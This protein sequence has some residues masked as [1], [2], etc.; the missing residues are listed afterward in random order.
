MNH[1]DMLARAKK[2]RGGLLF[3]LTIG[4]ALKI[5]SEVVMFITDVLYSTPASGSSA[6]NQQM[7]DRPLSPAA[8][9][10]N[11]TILEKVKQDLFR[12]EVRVL[13]ITDD[14]AQAKSRIKG[15]KAAMAAY[16]TEHQTLRAQWNFPAFILNRYRLYKF[17]HRLPSLLQHHSNKLAPSEIADIY[18]FPT[19]GS[20]AENMVQSLSRTLPATLSQKRGTDFDVIIGRNLHQE[21]QTDIGLTA[22]I[23]RKHMYLIGSTGT[24]KST[25]LESCIYQDMVKNKG[26]AVLEPHGD[27][28]Q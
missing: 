19:P 22:E 6:S 9:A 16:K 23:R 28:F 13:I 21:Q 8:Q 14:K 10:V 4:L 17:T 25:L 7:H 3:K 5:L 1:E 26:L 11:D 20:V 15:M 27:M 12:V 24:G 18:H 2:Q